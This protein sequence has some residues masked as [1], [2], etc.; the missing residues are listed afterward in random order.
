MGLKELI[1]GEKAEPSRRNE[2]F[3]RL[4]DG[5]RPVFH[6]W[7]GEL[8]ESELIRA[9]IDARARHI[10]KLSVEVKGTAKPTLQTNM[11][12]GPNQWQ[13]WGQF[14]YRLSTILDIKNTAIIVP[15][16]DEYGAT[17]GVYPVY[18]KEVELV[19][20][21]G[22][23]YIRIKF[24]NGEWGA[25]E[26]SK[27]GILTKFQS[28]N[29]FFGESNKA[30]RPTMELLS[31]QNQGIE[32]GVKS[33]A[34]YRFMA[35]VSNFSDPED[36]AKERK[37]FTKENLR[38]SDLD[39]VLL[40]PN[41]YRDVKQI[42]TKPYV[43]DP[44]QMTQI[45]ENVFDYFGVNEK[46]MKNEAIGDAWAA[47]YEG[48]IE[49][50]AIQLSDVMT[51]MLFTHR[52]RQQGSFI[53]AT[54]NRLQYMSTADKL[55]VS[56]QMADRGLMTRNEIREIWNLAPLPPEIGDQMPIRGEYYNVGETAQEGG[57]DAGE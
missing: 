29:D 23:R 22:V 34:T 48:A 57:T 27:A 19:E 53:M 36:L 3:F 2:E 45:R 41:T 49:P 16:I 1:F 55:N 5:Y 4:L 56:A 38:G 25:V 9:A 21:E 18:H 24:L 51:R 42:E 30:L 26:M 43:A 46:I 33:A 10:S 15:V 47:F 6:S 54:S 14:L 35:T 52:E 37:R 20:S 17:T 13:T 40:W 28:R 8:Y 50:F 32:E 11:K 44:E 39:G 7:G 12:L 31:I